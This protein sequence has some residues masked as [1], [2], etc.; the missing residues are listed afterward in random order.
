MMRLPIFT[1]NCAAVVQIVIRWKLTTP[2]LLPF[3]SAR[4]IPKFEAMSVFWLVGFGLR[5]IR[6]MAAVGCVIVAHTM[7]AGLSNNPQLIVKHCT[8]PFTWI[9]LWAWWCRAFRCSVALGTK[10]MNVSGI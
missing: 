1:R 9:R 2:V 3:V 6:G 7:A 4:F 8:W 10:A 5:G